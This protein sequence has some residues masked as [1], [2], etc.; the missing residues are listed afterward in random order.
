MA[1]GTTPETGAHLPAVKNR[2]SVAS[3]RDP[4]WNGRLNG[5][6]DQLS[7]GVQSFVSFR[8]DGCDLAKLTKGGGNFSFWRPVREVEN[9]DPLERGRDGKG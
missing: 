2:T 7:A 3:D 1:S 8:L 4:G 6:L 5:H 9:R